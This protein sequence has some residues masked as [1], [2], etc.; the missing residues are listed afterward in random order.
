MIQE[1]PG[2]RSSHLISSEVASTEEA[3]RLL[4]LPANKRILDLSRDEMTA[5]RRLIGWEP[6]GP[7]ISY[8]TEVERSARA[9]REAWKAQRSG[10][11]AEA[12]CLWLDPAQIDCFKRNLE[13]D[14]ADT[15]RWWG[16]FIHIAETLADLPLQT[17]SEL[18]TVQG[19]WT[20]AGSFCPK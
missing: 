20:F 5:F 10:N 11:G 4:G 16:N 14:D 1:G 9:E 3:L 15:Q 2:N 7:I 12:S 8:P 13:S 19:P 6:G 18:I 17:F